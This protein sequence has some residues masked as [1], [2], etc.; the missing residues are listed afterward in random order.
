MSDGAAG[1]SFYSSVKI[2]LV[3]LG[4]DHLFLLTAE[5]LRELL[6]ELLSELNRSVNC[7]VSHSHTELSRSLNRSL[8]H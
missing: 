3:F 4:S 8:N 1:I 7:L 5:S 6:N 2:Y